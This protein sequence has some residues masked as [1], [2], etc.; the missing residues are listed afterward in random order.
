MQCTLQRHAYG[1]VGSGNP[2]RVTED[3]SD[4]EAAAEAAARRRQEQ[5]QDDLH[6]QIAAMEVAEARKRLRER[7]LMELC[8]EEGA[9]GGAGSAAAAAVEPRELDPAAM[10]AAATAGILL[11]SMSYCGVPPPPVVS[12]AALTSPAGSANNAG[13]GA[14]AGGDAAAGGPQPAQQPA[15]LLSHSSSGVIQ[16]MNNPEHRTPLSQQLLK[17]ALRT[18]SSNGLAPPPSGGA[19][20]GA[21]SSGAGGGGGGGAHPPTHWPV[22]FAAT[23]MDILLDD[24]PTPTTP[25][26]RRA[27]SH[28][29]SASGYS[30]GDHSGSGGLATTS[31]SGNLSEGGELQPSSRQPQP[32]SQ[33]SQHQLLTPVPPSLARCLEESPGRRS[34][35]RRTTS[36][37]NAF[38]GLGLT[39]TSLSG[40]IGGAVASAGSIGAGSTGGTPRYR[41]SVPNSPMEMQ[42][43]ASSAAPGAVGGGSNGSRPGALLRARSERI[44]FSP[45]VLNAAPAEQGE[46]E[47]DGMGTGVD[48]ERAADYPRQS[49]AAGGPAAVLATVA[50]SPPLLLRARCSSNGSVKFSQGRPASGRAAAYNTA[51]SA[52][53][54][55]LMSGDAWGVGEVDDDDEGFDS[56]DHNAYASAGVPGGLGGGAGRGGGVW[57][58]LVEV[59]SASNSFTSARSGSGTGSGLRSGCAHLHLAAR[60]SSVTLPHSSRG[61]VGTGSSGSRPSTA[62]RA[63]RGAATGGV[64]AHA[65]SSPRSPASPAAVTAAQ[66]SGA[67]SQGQL[68]APNSPVTAAGANAA[69]TTAFAAMLEAAVPGRRLGRAKSYQQRRLSLGGVVRAN[70]AASASSGVGGNNGGTDS[71]KTDGAAADGASGAAAT[72]A[73]APAAT[74]DGGGGLLLSRGSLMAARLASKSFTV[75]SSSGS[76][77]WRRASLSIVVGGGGGGAGGGSS[78]G[79]T[80]LLSPHSAVPAATASLASPGPTSNGSTAQ[81]H[82]SPSA[83]GAATTDVTKST[84]ETCDNFRAI[85]LQVAG[86]TTSSVTLQAQAGSISG[87]ST[88]Q[89]DTTCAK[90]NKGACPKGGQQT[91][92]RTALESAPAASAGILAVMSD[93]TNANGNTAGPTF[94]FWLTRLAT[95]GYAGPTPTV[96]YLKT[97]AQIN[98]AIPTLHLYKLTNN[99]LAI[100]D[101]ITRTGGSLVANTQGGFGDAGFG[102][103][104]LKLTFVGGLTFSDIFQVQP[105]ATDLWGSG[106]TN[107]VLAQGPWHGYWTGPSGWVGLRPVVARTGACPTPLPTAS[108]AQ[109]CQATALWGKKVKLTAEICNNGIDDDGDG[110]IDGGVNGDPDCWRCG[111]GVI[112]P[113]EDCD[114][115]NITG[116]DGCSSECLFEI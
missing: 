14:V 23:G 26:A 15:R 45:N 97:A 70:A 110:L 69:A 73:V 44:R 71:G 2:D 74:G 98:A 76:G 25:G 67:A 85:T 56:G 41:M 95:V 5:E 31:R 55:T 84:A 28:V 30:G 105:D 91:V 34:L 16:F 4:P 75:G 93:T 109:N 90:N 7:L 33:P 12:T 113:C 19:A 29:S 63:S 13:T 3:G 112:D 87:G 107:A 9:G 79:R 89:C 61:A 96:T 22:R 35:R 115:G 38:A 72:A 24:S 49:P 42:F 82:C 104:P 88:R 27:L 114:D 18:A 17:P 66:Y 65:V 78:S 59:A 101:F 62:S 8:P 102:F 50:A 6:A 57:P 111:N 39:P 32:Q 37:N 36:S 48:V 52:S 68:V 40:G 21:A 53:A 11:R 94:Q 47:A 86:L 99:K 81:L 83:A 43:E 108:A 1:A 64:W 103:F 116:G 51:A 106:F 20:A 58:G 10:A 92:L 46:G 60:A 80:A 77:S 54:S 100:N